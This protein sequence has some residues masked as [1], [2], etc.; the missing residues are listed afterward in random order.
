MYPGISTCSWSMLLIQGGGRP[1]PLVGLNWL[2][3]SQYN[4]VQLTKHS[5]VISTV[6]DILEMTQ[7]LW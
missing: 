6:Y 5:A 3:L 7:K 1:V 2:S 4:S